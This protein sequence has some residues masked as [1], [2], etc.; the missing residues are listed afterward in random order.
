LLLLFID[1]STPS[2]FRELFTVLLD[3]HTFSAGHA[4]W[5]HGF[6]TGF[7]GWIFAS[8]F[9]TFAIFTFFTLALTVLAFTAFALVTL[10]FAAFVLVTLTLAALGFW[11]LFAVLLLGH[12]FL[13][14]KA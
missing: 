8:W 6:A 2:G 9:L 12:T 3:G 1:V 5:G 11:H 14:G 13:T 4:L 10:A 7:L